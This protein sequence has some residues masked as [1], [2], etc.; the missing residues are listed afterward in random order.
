MAKEVKVVFKTNTKD[1]TND[2]K[3]L[4]TEL[5][6]TN[7]TIDEATSGLDNMSGG[8]ISAM[9]GIFKGAKTAAG[10]FRT[11]K[12]A[13]ISTGIGALVVVVGS[14]IEYFSNFRAGI[15]LVDKAMA[16]LGAVMGQLGAAA[17]AFIELDF[18]GVREALLGI[19]DAVKESVEA[20]NDQYTAEDELYKLRQK[21]IVQQAELEKQMKAQVKIINDTTLSAKERL[22]AV[23]RLD[24]IQK[25]ILENDKQE[26]ALK[27]EILQA[28]LTTENNENAR[29]EIV[30]QI[31]ELTAEGIKKEGEL[32]D[33][34]YDS[35]QRRREILK[36]EEDKANAS[37]EKAKADEEKEA[38]EKEKKDAEDLAKKKLKAKEL[39]DYKKQL[40]DTLA[41]TEE[42]R[43]ALED[44]RLADD[45]KKL[46][47]NE[48][49]TA[50]E[51]ILIR[52][53]YEA[54]VDEINAKR[55]ADDDAVTQAA[56]AKS[57]EEAKAKVE[58]NQAVEDAKINAAVQGL[59][60]AASLAK[61]GSDLA[62]GLAVASTVMST[63]Q[64]A[65]AMFTSAAASPI[66]TAFPAFPFIQAGLA[67]AGGLANVQ[68]ILSTDP[69]GQGGASVGG[70]VPSAPSIG[71]TSSIAVSTGND[72]GSQ[73]GDAINNKP[74]RSYVVSGDVTTQQG[75]DRRIKTNATFG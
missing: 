40:D 25:K 35:Q 68:K 55:A 8:G 16:G 21:T 1:V 12:G 48:N 22:A 24:E 30:E 70:G 45:F 53:A 57:K 52:E 39:A 19:G 71:A 62:K 60:L 32:N 64:G 5:G 44:Q 69:T 3:G 11:L 42:E 9:K 14:L 72:V 37:K 49:A 18:D 50:K 28:Q 27:K 6:N 4:N 31:N 61:E 43:R 74:V 38:A 41:D 47:D 66:T 67:V 26:I 59:N 58:L 63:W 20:V 36:G 2:V 15:E 75:L 7:E 65:Q 13:I 29:R 73:I 46:M 51:K 23:N 10:G 17:K 34:N 56:I 33:I 54:R